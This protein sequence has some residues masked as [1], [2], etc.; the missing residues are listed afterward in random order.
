MCSLKLMMVIWDIVFPYYMIQV[1]SLIFTR[2]IYL[3]LV[4]F[5][6]KKRLKILKLFATST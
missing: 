5:E 6:E 4:L 3:G 1:F 2:V